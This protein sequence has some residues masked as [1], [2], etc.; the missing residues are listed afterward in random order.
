MIVSVLFHGEQIIGRVEVLEENTIVSPEDNIL[1]IRLE[2]QTGLVKE[3]MK[4]ALI[5]FDIVNIPAV[6]A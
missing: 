5:S 3:L 4:E 6:R 2:K 1:I